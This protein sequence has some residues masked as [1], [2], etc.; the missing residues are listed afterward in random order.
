[1]AFKSEQV[2]KLLAE[3]IAKEGANYVKKVG[4]T[5]SF[6]VTKGTEEK[7]WLVDLKSGS[8]SVKEGKV[9]ADCTITT[10]DESFFGLFTG[11]ANPQELFFG[12][13]LKIDGDMGLAMSLSAVTEG[14][15]L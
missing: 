15:K 9:P 2:M 4:G 7:A 13:K 3:R 12:G 5:Y 10:D 1:M 11:K 8:G 6:V 14:A